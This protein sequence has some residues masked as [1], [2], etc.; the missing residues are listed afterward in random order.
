MSHRGSEP[1]LKIDGLSIRG[2]ETIDDNG[3][4][5]IEEESNRS[6]FSDR[7]GIQQS[8]CLPL[9]SAKV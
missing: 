9:V 5:G 6:D 7:C 8:T 1:K 4:A 3:I 2:E